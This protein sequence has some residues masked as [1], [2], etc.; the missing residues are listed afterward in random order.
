MLQEVRLDPSLTSAEPELSKGYVYRTRFITCSYYCFLRDCFALNMSKET[1]KIRI[2]QLM[3][4][5]EGEDFPPAR[6]GSRAAIVENF[7][8]VFGGATR[9]GEHFNDLWRCEIGS[10]EAAM[11]GV[12][13]AHSR[14]IR[15][16]SV[17]GEPPSKRSGHSFIG[18]GLR[19][20]MV[21]GGMISPCNTGYSQ[22]LNDTFILEIGAK[23]ESF[24][25]HAPRIKG[26]APSRRTEHSSKCLLKN[27]RNK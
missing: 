24:V 23:G 20:V 22:V 14:W 17:S 15:V 27:N 5:M 10:N 2:K 3:P 9:L 18:I 8:Y 26:E 1:H 4:C 11:N 16:D 13:S 25:W 19:R 12:E 6:G 21:F 7:V